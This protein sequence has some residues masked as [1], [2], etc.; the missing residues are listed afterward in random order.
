MTT[1]ERDG[2]TYYIPFSNGTE[3]ETYM[4]HHCYECASENICHALSQ[5]V[6]GW[7]TKKIYDWIGGEVKSEKGFTYLAS[8]QHLKDI[9][10]RARVKPKRCSKTID[11]FG[12]SPN[13]A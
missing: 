12:G 1:I 11:V 10:D 4:Y 8:C 7:I 6:S 5:L 9:K 13:D 3:S 2:I